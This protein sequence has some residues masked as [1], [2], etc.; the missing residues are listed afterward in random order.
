VRDI[1]AGEADDIGLQRIDGLNGRVKASLRSHATDVKVGH[2]GD[3]Q[4]GMSKRQSWR[5]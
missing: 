2:V 1:V 5:L 4:T 3:P